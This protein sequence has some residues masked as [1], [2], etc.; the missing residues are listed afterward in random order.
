MPMDNDRLRA[1]CEREFVGFVEG[2]FKRA[3][4]IPNSF[5][6]ETPVI[7]GRFFVDWDRDFMMQRVIRAL[8]TREQFRRA[9]P[10]WPPLPLS[11][12]DCEA[13]QNADNPRLNVLGLYGGSLHGEARDHRHPRFAPFVGALMFCAKT[14]EEIRNDV[15]LQRAFPPCQV[16]GFDDEGLVW[17]SPEMR[18]ALAQNAKNIAAWEAANPGV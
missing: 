5:L 16:D 9:M 1:L 7:G 15:D 8:V 11:D 18:A 6:A 2:L 3:R 12:I 10:G 17:R 14:P 13:M 4:R